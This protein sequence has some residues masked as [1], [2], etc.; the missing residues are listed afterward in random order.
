MRE[1][2]V[3]IYTGNGKGKTTAA[4]GLAFRALGYGHRVIIIQF[5]KGQTCGEHIHAAKIRL[6][7]CQCLQ[8]RGSEPCAATCPLFTEAAKILKENTADVLILDEIMAA[9]HHGCLSVTQVL[10][11]LSARPRSCEIVMTGRNAPQE[12]IDAADLVT[13]MEPVKHYFKSGVPARE[14]IEF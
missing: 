1:G 4:F 8:G 7:I 5:Q 9:I 14:G 12:L 13:S 10:E 11:L 3:Q 2:K 6:P